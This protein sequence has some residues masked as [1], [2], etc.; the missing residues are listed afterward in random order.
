MS[1]F[2]LVDAIGQTR[3]YRPG[4][5]EPAEGGERF[6]KREKIGEVSQLLQGEES[7][8]TELLKVVIKEMLRLNIFCNFLLHLPQ[9]LPFQVNVC[10]ASTN[11]G[12]V[13]LKK[14][15]GKTSP[16]RGA[17]CQ[18]QIIQINMYYNHL[19]IY[20]HLFH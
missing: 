7:E 12:L 3:G 9:E 15:K 14:E 10:I 20:N 11:W 13:I 4:H 18:L 19:F 16:K 8:R 5:R 6:G 2:V 1:D 17:W